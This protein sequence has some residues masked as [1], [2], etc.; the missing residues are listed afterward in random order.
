NS[1][2]RPA[3]ATAISIL[4]FGAAAY[5]GVIG[6]MM[7]ASPGIVSMAAGAALLNGLELAGPYMF[8]LVSALTALTAWGM[9][10][11]QSWAR[12]ITILAAFA[13]FVMLIPSVSA[14]AVDFRWSLLS[15][16]LGIIVRMV[17]VWYL[18]Q[19][20]VAEQFSKLF[21]KKSKGD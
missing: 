11:M 16:G 3:G 6:A 4:L 20:P 12:R 5:L 1:M 9:L 7:L 19:T 13:G 2:P 21:A 10:R 17:V 14:A 18:W 15:G 8:L